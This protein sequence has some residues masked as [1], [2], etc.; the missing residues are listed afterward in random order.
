MSHSDV[1]PAIVCHQVARARHRH[2]IKL[3]KHEGNG[4]V[5]IDEAEEVKAQRTKLFVSAKDVDRIARY[6][7]PFVFIAFNFIYWFYFIMAKD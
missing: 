3:Q 2:T 4:T 5:M 1:D 7:F 6:M